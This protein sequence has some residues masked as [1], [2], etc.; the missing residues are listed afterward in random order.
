MYHLPYLVK[1]QD[2]LY[3]LYSLL[4]GQASCRKLEKNTAPLLHK[5]TKCISLISHEKAEL[6]Y[7]DRETH[8]ILRF[9]DHKVNN[10]VL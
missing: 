3:T 6:S 10:N 1:K 9:G 7:I 8:S 4:Y 2:K 5:K